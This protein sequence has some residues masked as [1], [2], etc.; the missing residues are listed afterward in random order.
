[1]PHIMISSKFGFLS[2]F[3][4]FSIFVSDERFLDANVL[5]LQ[6]PGRGQPLRHF[7][8]KRINFVYIVMMLSVLSLDN[9]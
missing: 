3:L 8:L 6:N 2:F 4:R 9:M 1:M 5:V 7:F